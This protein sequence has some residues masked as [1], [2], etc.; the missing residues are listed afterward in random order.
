MART[1][2][3]ACFSKSAVPIRSN[4]LEM[5]SEA[6]PDFWTW[7]FWLAVSARASVLTVRGAGLRV[8]HLSGIGWFATPLPAGQ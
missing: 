3:W 6:P 2:P 1:H 4:N 5:E 8:A 7:S